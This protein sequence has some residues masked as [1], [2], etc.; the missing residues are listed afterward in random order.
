MSEPTSSPVAFISHSSRDKDRFVRRLEAGLRER[1]VRTIFDERDFQLG[2]AV[3][4]A[5]FEEGI[6]V[7]DV[8]VMVLSRASLASDFVKAERDAAVMRR[9][10]EGVP[11]LLLVLDSLRSEDVPM[12]LRSLVRLHV[13]PLDAASVKNAITRTADAAH[14]KKAAQQLGPPPPWT[15]VALP[16]LTADPLDAAMLKI[17]AETA[18]R[19][20][21]SKFVAREEFFCEAH[22]LQRPHEEAEDSLLELAR[23]GW[24]QDNG[25]WFGAGRTARQ[26]GATRAGLD[27]W[28]RATDSGYEERLRVVAAS[29]LNDGCRFNVDVERATGFEAAFVDH[30]LEELEARGL[31]QI[32]RVSARGRLP[33]SATAAL[34]RYLMQ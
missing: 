30:A 18:L 3:P 14:G 12:S 16:V 17:A 33:V 4:D 19:D 1:H 11:I 27:R 9:I 32:R 7:A 34:R 2:Q 26:Y 21:F 10:E 29:L 13:D 23:L 22:R 15:V 6:A 24:L 20:R 25:D 31:V 8:V 5:M 28:L